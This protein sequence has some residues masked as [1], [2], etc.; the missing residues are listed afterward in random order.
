MKWN[1]FARPA[2][3]L[4]ALFWAG[5]GALAADDGVSIVVHDQ[6]GASSTEEGASSDSAFWIEDEEA[7]EEASGPSVRGHIAAGG[8]FGE[9]TGW[10]GA[11]MI[12]WGTIYLGLHGGQTE[13]VELDGVG[14]DD[15]EYDFYSGMIG[16]RLPWFEGWSVEV[17]A[18]GSQL[19]DAAEAPWVEAF[20]WQYG[21]AYTWVGE[22]GAMIH[23]AGHGYDVEGSYLTTLTD[24]QGLTFS[25]WGM[26]PLAES[27]SAW[28]SFS[29]GMEVEAGAATALGVPLSWHVGT[30]YMFTENFGIGVAYGQTDWD[31]GLLPDSQTNEVTA[32]LNIA[33]G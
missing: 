19:T 8:I 12:D 25:A 32:Y 27:W 20:G 21:L 4:L 2:L 24:D 29:S 5:A 23:V 31:A 15:N 9:Q 33:L 16:W 7:D 13:D 3:A 10:M 18:V 14:L 28:V 1:L 6:E 30:D 17:G 22:T 26:L 11:G